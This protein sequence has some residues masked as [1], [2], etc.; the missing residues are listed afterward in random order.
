MIWKKITIESNND[1]EDII[2]SILFDNGIFGVEIEDNIDLSKE[3]LEKMY[4]DIPL[5]KKDT[6]RA[7]VSFYISIRNDKINKNENVDN[8][9]IDNSYKAYNDNIYTSDEFETVYKKIIAD[10]ECYNGIIDLKDILITEKDLDD[11]EYLYKWKDNFKRI[12]IDEISIIPSWDK[13]SF[14][15][16]T[17]IYIEPGNAFGT[18]QHSTTMLCIKALKNILDNNKSIVN[19]LDIGCGSGILSITAKKLGVKNVYAIDVD[20]TIKTNLLDNLKLNNIDNI[21][22]INEI[23]DGKEKN[24]ESNGSFLYGFGNIIID[25]VLKDYLYNIKFDIILA[26]ILSPVLISLIEKCKI[27]KFL[28]TN[29]HLILS[30]IIKD[31]ED[32]VTKSINQNIKYKKLLLDYDNDWVSFTINI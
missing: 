25:D 22:N 30:G 20:D 5:K 13:K 14:A 31:K 23:I 27:N 12:D 8:S 21:L 2:A 15:N 1:A 26:N 18:G 29:G 17:N 19:V 9:L 4:V 28:N 6:G 32:E 10:L 7:K 3:D 16:K 24:T 11:K